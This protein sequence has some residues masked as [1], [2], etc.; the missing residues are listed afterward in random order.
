MDTGREAAAGS[1]AGSEYASV[2]RHRRFGD[3]RGVKNPLTNSEMQSWFERWRERWN[4]ETGPVFRKTIAAREA[5]H[6]RMAVGLLAARLCELSWAADRH[7]CYVHHLEGCPK[8]RGFSLPRPYEGEWQRYVRDH[9]LSDVEEHLI[10]C[11]RRR[12]YEA[13]H[14]SL[15]RPQQEPPRTPPR[16]PARPRA[17]QR[18]APNYRPWDQASGP[19]SDG[20]Q[21][22]W[23]RGDEHRDE[24]RRENRRDEGWTPQYD[25]YA[26]R[27]RQEVQDRHAGIEQRDRWAEAASAQSLR[28]L[29]DR[30]E[31]LERENEELRR[32]VRPWESRR[33]E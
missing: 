26:Q 1:D 29:A 11:Y 27:Y 10:G 7:C 16:S 5:T 22:S 12:L 30:V 33:G 2:L 13:R 23:R 21:V 17:A 15:P 6:E 9:P 31:R 8:C 18:G 3:C 20:D 32:R 14:G 28:R 4:C 25:G 24:G 19:G